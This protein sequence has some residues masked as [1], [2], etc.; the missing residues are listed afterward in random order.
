MIM[1][2]GISCCTCWDDVG[3]GAMVFMDSS[4]YFLGVVL[5]FGK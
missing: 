3:L 2:I 4:L 1:L 5:G